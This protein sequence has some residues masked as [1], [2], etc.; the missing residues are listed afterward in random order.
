[1]QCAEKTSVKAPV[2]LLAKAAQ[3]AEFLARLQQDPVNTLAAE[4]VRLEELALPITI[5]L[6][7]NG[8]FPRFFEEGEVGPPVWTGFF[9]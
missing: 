7:E 3:N 1:M 2:S 9:A 5:T 6:P 4:G 8:E